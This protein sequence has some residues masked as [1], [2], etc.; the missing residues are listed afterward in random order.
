M[1]FLWPKNV[2]GILYYPPD[3]SLD[4]D[5]HPDSA[6]DRILIYENFFRHTCMMYNHLLRSWFL[7]A[8]RLFCLPV[9]G[10][11]A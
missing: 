1:M 8:F 6:V 9:I 11:Y 4:P 2:K 3:P 7:S 5:H 10:E